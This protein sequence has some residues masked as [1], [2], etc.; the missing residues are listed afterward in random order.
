MLRTRRADVERALGTSPRRAPSSPSC[1]STQPRRANSEPVK[2][3]SPTC[4][5]VAIA[6][7]SASIAARVVAGALVEV[8][9]HAEAHREHDRPVDPREAVGGGAVVRSAVGEVAVEHREL[10]QRVRRGRATAN[11]SS[12]DCAVEVEHDPRGGGGPRRGR[13]GPRPARRRTSG[14]APS[15]RRRRGARRSRAPSPGPRRCARSRRPGSRGARGR[16]APAPAC[17]R[18]PRRRRRRRR[19]ASACPRRPCRPASGA[20]SRRRRSSARSRR[21]RWRPP[22]RA[23]P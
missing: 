10:P 3:R 2:P 23:Q 16:S 14:P 21:R 19:R 22:T 9:D 17:A 8:G 13:R 12:G 7:S 6:A 15:T 18:P 1:S 5:L 11:G 20:S 4:S